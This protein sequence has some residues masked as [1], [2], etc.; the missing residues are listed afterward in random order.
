MNSLAI[1]LPH[2][3]MEKVLVGMVVAAVAVFL[4]GEFLHA[5]T[6]R[7]LWMIFPLL[8]IAGVIHVGR[9]GAAG[10]QPATAGHFETWRRGVE[11]RL[12]ASDPPEYLHLIPPNFHINYDR[13][14]RAD[15]RAAARQIVMEGCEALVLDGRE[16]RLKLVIKLR[17]EPVLTVEYSLPDGVLKEE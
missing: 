6:A 14:P 2:L 10:P 3:T 9:R 17:W 16:A 15:L 8:A 12:R 13:L 5:K 7:V 11:E 1:V 4:I